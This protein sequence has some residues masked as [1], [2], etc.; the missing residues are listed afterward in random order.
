MLTNFFILSEMMILASEV[1]AKYAS[2]NGLPAPYRTQSSPI[3]W[4]PSTD[5]SLD[6]YLDPWDIP[7]ICNPYT[8]M[9]TSKTS[10]SKYGKNG[11]EI[12]RQKDMNLAEIF[13]YLQGTKTAEHSVEPKPHT[14]VGL[15]A[16]LRATSPIRR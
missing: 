5:D 1:A 3:V 4:T 9:D 2:K 10:K 6:A 14:G 11:S 15:E 12:M 7:L 8:E 13:R 16:Y